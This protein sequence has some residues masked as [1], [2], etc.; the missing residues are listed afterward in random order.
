MRQDVL[1][2]GLFVTMTACA[3]PNMRLHTYADYL[4]EAVGHA[5]HDVVAKQMGAPHRIAAL[6]K[7][8]DLWTYEICHRSTVDA[9][10]ATSSTG[11][12]SYPPGYCQN[13]NLVF[14]N[15]GRLAEWHD[16]VALIK[17]P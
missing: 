10:K 3:L 7:G 17:R 5:D 2:L 1:C 9:S 8:G 12:I 4:N 6:D 11:T 15:S 16:T 13:L 14:D